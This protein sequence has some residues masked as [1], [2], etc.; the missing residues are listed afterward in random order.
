MRAHSQ[1]PAEANFLGSL[2]RQT[3]L[4]TGSNTT[5]T[6]CKRILVKLARQHS[7]RRTNS[8]P[9]QQRKKDVSS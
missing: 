1:T 7:S 4:D 5:A 8:N 3:I 9:T 6:C 2:L